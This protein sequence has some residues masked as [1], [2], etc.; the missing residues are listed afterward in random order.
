MR[1][2]VHTM[3]VHHGFTRNFNPIPA[4][5]IPCIRAGFPAST[6]I[7]V[8]KTAMVMERPQTPSE[9]FGRLCG[10]YKAEV[11]RSVYPGPD[12][13]AVAMTKEAEETA[14]Y[15]RADA[16][17]MAKDHAAQAATAAANAA[18]AAETEKQTKGKIR[19]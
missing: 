17:R 7:K 10:D 12:A 6:H 19:P 4:Y 14:A 15:E 9:E 16:A 5:E 13:L 1:F 11:V 2:Q 8:T 3:D 18:Q